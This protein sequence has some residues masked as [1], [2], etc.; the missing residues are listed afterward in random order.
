MKKIYYI[1]SINVIMS[2]IYNV[3]GINY[4]EKY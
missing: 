4:C 2:D 3:E 1:L